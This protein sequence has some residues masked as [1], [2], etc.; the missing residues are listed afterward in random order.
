MSG[1]LYPSLVKSEIIQSECA[2][3]AYLEKPFEVNLH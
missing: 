3:Y 1:M 2:P